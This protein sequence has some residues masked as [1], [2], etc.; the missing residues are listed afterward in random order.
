MD[1]FLRDEAAIVCIKFF[2]KLEEQFF[3]VFIL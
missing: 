3:V 1:F 2:E